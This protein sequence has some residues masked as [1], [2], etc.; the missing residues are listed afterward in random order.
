MDQ[1]SSRILTYRWIVFL[2]ASGYWIYQFQQVLDPTKG[3][4]W[5]FRYLTIWALTASL[6]SALAVLR[7][8]LGATNCRPE[9]LVG[10]TA[11]LNGMVVYLYWRLYLAD[12]ANVN[13][14]SPILWWQEY[15]LHGLGP[16]LQWIDAFLILGVFRRPLPVVGTLLAVVFVYVGWSELVV[17]P[18]NALPVGSIT[19][20]LPYPF[21]NNMEIGDR[22]RFYVTSFIMALGI[23]GLG[24]GI[25]R[26][27]RSRSR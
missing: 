16:L 2:L 18:T 24:W 11:V 3:F 6:L 21:L 12:P 5:Q 22:I 9:T 8:S 1:R 4:G 23:V 19:S 10:V 13:D 7:L 25:S 14:G 26:M 15:Y 27:V 17:Q 20:G